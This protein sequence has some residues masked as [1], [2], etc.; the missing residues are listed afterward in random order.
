MFGEITNPTDPTDPNTNFH[1]YINDELLEYI[2]SNNEEINLILKYD[3]PSTK[4]IKN[5]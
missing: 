4:L 1:I 5:R 3:N 2:N